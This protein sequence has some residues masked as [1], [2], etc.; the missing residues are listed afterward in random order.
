MDYRSTNKP[1][2]QFALD[3]ADMVRAKPDVIVSN[4]AEPQLQAVMPVSGLIPIVFWANNFDPIERGY[5]KS[6]VR[7]G[8][9]LT[10]VFTRQPE[11][12]EKQVELLTQTFP[13]R[14]RLGAL[15]DAGTRDGRAAAEQK[16][17]ALR[18][19]VCM[20]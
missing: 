16:K 14:T 13:E 1:V 8:G 4:G 19:A 7:P 18:P 12:A 15:W 17:G 11:L 5:V 2:A 9:N 3:L 10:G 6:L 20:R